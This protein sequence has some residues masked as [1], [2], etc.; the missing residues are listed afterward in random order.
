MNLDL[1]LLKQA[2]RDLGLNIPY[3]KGTNIQVK[4]CWH[5]TTDGNSIDVIFEDDQD[6]KDGMNRVFVVSRDYRVLIL[7]FC[8]M[9]THVH[10]ILYGS[11]D[12]CNAFIHKYIQQTS[13]Y[14]NTRHGHIRKLLNLPIHHQVIDDDFYLKTAICYVLKNPPVGGLS[15]SAYDYPWSSGSLY[16]RSKGQWNSSLWLEDLMRENLMDMDVLE[17]RSLLK[18]RNVHFP[19]VKIIRGVICPDEYVCYKL[20]EDIFRTHKSFNYFM[21][22]TKDEDV[23]SKGGAISRLSIPIQEMRQHRDEICHELFQVAT[24][25]M[26]DVKQRLRLARVIKSRYNSSSKQIARLCGLLYT[27]VKDLV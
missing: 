2:E 8:L 1:D 13:R 21:C 10:F 9:D 16:F 25:R 6:F 27:E 18:T 12:E 11:Y 14:I 20:V 24:I 23:E 22:R 15:Y 4:D 19:D 5:F 7:A 3:R 17:R 26:L